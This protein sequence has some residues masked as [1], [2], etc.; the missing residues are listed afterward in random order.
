[1][2]PPKKKPGTG[3]KPTATRTGTRPA[4]ARPTIPKAAKPAGPQV[5]TAPRPK[6]PTGAGP[7]LVVGTI[8]PLARLA[9]AVALLAAALLLLRPAFPLVRVAGAGVGGAHNLADFIVP[10]PVVAAAAWAGVLCLLGRLP[11]FGLAVLI[12][13]GAYG[14]GGAIRLLPLF[15]TRRRSTL[16]LPLPEGAVHY[17][18]YSAGP[19]LVLAVISLLVLAAAALLALLAW[20]RTVMEDDGSFDSLRPTFGLLGALAAGNAVLAVLYAPMSGQPG[21]LGVPVQALFSR[22]GLDQFGTWVQMLGFVAVA[23]GAAIAR[24]RLSVVGMFAGLGAVSLT[25][26]F[27]D[28]L[29]AARSTV[30]T[31][32]IGTWIQVG[33][34]FWCLLFALGAWKLTRRRPAR[35][36]DVSN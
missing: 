1:M 11:R 28:G 18:R 16:D 30:L 13:T 26:G 31:V 22:L 12:A 20:R 15:S 4:G 17:A 21:A 2:S 14:L 29:L 33:L 23:V 24:P 25:T 7:V 5:T 10:L 6:G 8:P 27:A 36:E 34:G 3:A 9:S 19:G 32:D 35:G